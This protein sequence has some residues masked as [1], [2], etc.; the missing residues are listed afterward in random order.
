MTKIY[1]NFSMGYDRE[2][3]ALISSS[4]KIGNGCIQLN[5]E[6][7][8][9]G[10]I[11]SFS[12]MTIMFWCKIPLPTI[13][14]F[15][16]G[17]HNSWTGNGAAMWH[18]ANDH[19]VSILCRSDAESNYCGF[20][21]LQNVIDNNWHHLA[22]TY[23]GTQ[24]KVYKDGQLEF[25][26]SYGNNGK[27]NN[28]NLL[29]GGGQG[30]NNEAGLI[31]EFKVYGSCFSEEDI[32][33]E[34]NRRASLSDKGQL[35]I[36]VINEVGDNKFDSNTSGIVTGTTSSLEAYLYPKPNIY[37]FNNHIYYA[38]I[39]GYQDIVSSGTSIDFFWPET[40]TGFRGRITIKPSQQWN[41]YSWRFTGGTGNG[42]SIASGTYNTRFDYNNQ[43]NANSI[44]FRDAK[45]FDLTEMF[46]SGNEPT[47]A[48]CDS[49]FNKSNQM[50]NEKGIC[51]PSNNICEMGRAMRYL[52]IT[53]NGSDKNG[54]NHLTKLS[55]NTI[56]NNKIEIL[57]ITKSTTCING[58]I[59]SGTLTPRKSTPAED[60]YWDVSKVS[61]F[62]LGRTE[63]VA[64][65]N[66]RRYYIDI[67]Y[68]YQTKLEGS[69]DNQNWFT[70]WDSG[71]TG[72]Y[73]DDKT[74]NTYIETAQGRNF[75]VDC[76]NAQISENG[77]I[78]A[79]E[80][81]EN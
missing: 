73:G 80:F 58:S 71:N 45:L 62:D 23:S 76:E 16:F 55:Y 81:I 46:G 54:A 57:D 11:G 53:M 50:V 24:A 38:S 40:N 64:F 61:T 1:D 59:I 22:F 43:N 14:R 12:Q 37:L 41:L 60:N 18:D 13:Q 6:N 56:N 39:W 33:R 68:Y 78:I 31:D 17:S 77:V 72:S 51:E 26:Q 66:M 42:G 25:T 7:I 28:P 67:R 15:L 35:F 70:I 8:A 44:M 36:S 65:I 52:K 27:I 49:I 48:E 9:V 5:N 69:L 3:S 63:M 4:S 29:I 21:A 10:N 79:S 30:F 47:Q 20:P 75:I 74:Y 2:T 32:Q 34:Y 19:Q